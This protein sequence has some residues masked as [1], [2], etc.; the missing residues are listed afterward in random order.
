M[1]IHC[2][3]GLTP[4]LKELLEALIHACRQAEPISLSLPEDGRYYL[5]IPGAPSISSAPSS[6]AASEGS[7]EISDSSETPAACLILCPAGPDLWECYA[8]TRPDCRRQGLFTRLYGKALQLAQ[9]EGEISGQEPELV[10]LSDGQSLQGQAALEAMGLE[11]WY[12]EHQMEACIKDLDL[13]G[14]ST[15]TARPL[16]LIRRRFFDQGMESWLYLAFLSPAAGKPA[17]AAQAAAPVQASAPTQA[18]GQMPPASLPP[19]PS[20]QPK[21]LA[22]RPR[23]AG[24]CRLLPY[25]GGRFYLYHLEIIPDYRGY[26]LGRSLLHAVLAS[27][28]EDTQVILQ[29]SS[30]NTAA[31]SLYKKT[32]FRITKTLSYHNYC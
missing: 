9:K 24:T 12:S 14:S 27:L 30:E 7:G 22:N 18:P 15:G 10:F 16:R 17:G 31:L 25:G 26:G 23:C 6:S 4:R 3:E 28:P 8:F 21:P 20:R 32:G 1:V 29:V 13:T 11:L 2:E 5:W 19:S